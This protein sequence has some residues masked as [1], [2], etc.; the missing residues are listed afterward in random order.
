MFI[1]PK[2]EL[3]HRRLQNES[4]II[5]K[6][7]TRCRYWSLQKLQMGAKMKNFSYFVNNQLDSKRVISIILAW[8]WVSST[9]SKFQC[10]ILSWFRWFKAISLSI[11]FHRLPKETHSYGKHS[12]NSVQCS[13]MFGKYRWI[14][15]LSFTFKY[16]NSAWAKRELSYMKIL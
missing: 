4:S 15:I 12:F 11:E 9:F 13:K 2:V 3:H 8:D 14:L 10:Q 6:T 7:S 1:L 5:Q 16:A